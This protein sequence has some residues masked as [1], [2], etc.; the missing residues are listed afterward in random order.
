MAKPLEAVIDVRNPNESIL[1]V[2]S[3]PVMLGKFT[4]VLRSQGYNVLGFIEPETAQQYL[5]IGYELALA[6]VDL[7][8]EEGRGEDLAAH[9]AKTKPQMPV[10]GTSE[11]SA[12]LDYKGGYKKVLFKPVKDST[13]TDAIS[14]CL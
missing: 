7:N 5:D 6:V 2:E 12:P 11:L 4:E 13:L 3:D 10:I 8:F 1:V 9:I 14:L